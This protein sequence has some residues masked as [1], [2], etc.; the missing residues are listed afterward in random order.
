LFV[1]CQTDKQARAEAMLGEFAELSLGV[2]KELAL[3]L[4][5][6]EDMGEAAALANAFQ[7][8]SRVMR[9]TLALDF[10]LDRDAAREARAEAD[11]ARH[12][13]EAEAA[14]R[15]MA[16]IEADAPGKRVVGP[17]EARQDR[18]LRLD[19]AAL[20]PDFE[21]LP[22]ETLARRV[23]ADMGLSGKLSLSL[24]EPPPGAVPAPELPAP[25]AAETELPDTG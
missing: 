25:Q 20:S 18:V 21:T 4:R 2:A 14:E 1:T 23:I 16:E 10:K 6:C 15:R 5:A 17:I 8:T 12:A 22:L 3:R 9:L 11:A 19:E 7:K 13:A 24:S